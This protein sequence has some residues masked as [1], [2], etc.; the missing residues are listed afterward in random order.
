[1][2][3]SLVNSSSIEALLRRLEWTVIRRLDGLL[4]GDYRTLMR[5]AGLDLADLREY[6]HHDDVR[7]IDWNVTAR[8]QTPH[9]RQFTEDRELTAWF[10]LDLS[11]SVDFGSQDRSKRTVSTEFVAVLA[12]LMTRHGNRVG[13]LLFGSQVDAVLPARGGRL[14]VLHLLQRMRDFKPPQSSTE[15]R[16]RDLLQAAQQLIPRRSMV[17]V[18]SDFISAPGW[19]DAMARLAQKHE[20][21]AVRL[22]DPAE[23]ELPDVGLM[24]I[25]D[26]ETGEQVFVDTH[27][28]G[29]RERF[30]RLADERESELRIALTRAG[31]DT[32]ELA[33]DDDLVNTVMRFAD[34]RRQRSRTSGGAIQSSR[35]P[36]RMRGHLAVPGG[37]VA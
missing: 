3:E 27:D 4:Q 14:H 10:L 8:L 7:H 11:G 17:F 32:L 1:M 13:A 25:Q 20:V 37:T 30:V 16:L 21:L 18:V 19:S 28:P 9:V 15:T 23:M 33:T 22:F 34:M 5:G 35:P 31:V 2:A 29:F 36:D 12:R 24:T 26:A 6:Q